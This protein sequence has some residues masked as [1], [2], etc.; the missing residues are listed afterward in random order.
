MVYQKLVNIY[1][2][3]P[4]IIDI[5]RLTQNM[6]IEVYHNSITNY[7]VNTLDLKS[8]NLT[9]VKSFWWRRP[10]PVIANYEIIDESH[11]DFA[12]NEWNNALYG[13]WQ[14]LID[15]NNC[16]WI[17]DI[18]KDK[19]ASYKPYQLTVAKKIGLTIPHTLITNNPNQ[20][21]NP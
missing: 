20:L 21:K 16:L 15:K 13:I 12:V 11:R 4:I 17:N 2:Q 3:H 6:S 7:I 18:S 8:I 10:Q 1:E 9:E 14:S 19:L 5:S